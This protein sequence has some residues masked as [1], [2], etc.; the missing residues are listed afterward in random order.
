M[1]KNHRSTNAGIVTFVA[2]ADTTGFLRMSSPSTRKYHDCLVVE[3]ATIET[4]P[5]A[6]HGLNI[7]AITAISSTIPPNTPP[8][9]KLDPATPEFVNF[10]SFSQT[11]ARNR[12]PM[13]E[14]HNKTPDEQK[15]PKSLAL[16][17]T[18]N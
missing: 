16:P 9:A 1:A 14:T 8:T 13:R 10:L 15:T 18:N 2:S 3:F 5:R 11:A 7:R 6:Y 17:T 12:K 4:H